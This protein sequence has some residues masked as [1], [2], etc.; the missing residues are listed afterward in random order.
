MVETFP[1]EIVAY[2]KIIAL[3]F[4]SMLS[5]TKSEKIGFDVPK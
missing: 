2:L 1:R 5:Q 4:V 3:A